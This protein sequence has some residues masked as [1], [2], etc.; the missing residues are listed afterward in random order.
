MSHLF[1]PLTI[2][3]V[4]LRNRIGVSPMCQYSATD[5]VPNDWHLVHYGSRATG[6]AGLIIVEAAAVE[7]RGRISPEDLG[8]YSEEQIPA[9]QR[10]TAFMKENGAVPGIQLAHAGRKASTHSPFKQQGSEPAVA[11]ENGGWD[12]IGP[13]ALPF[14]EGYKTPKEATI[15]EIKEIQ[16]KFRQATIAAAKAG[17]EWLEFHAAHGYLAHSFYSPLSNKRT[18]EYGGSFENRIRFTLETAQIMR[19][20]WPDHLPFTVRISATDWTEGGWTIEE[21]VELSKRLKALGVD[22]IDCS[23]GGNVSDAK[24]PVGAGYQ[25]TF[26]ERIRNEASIATAAVGLITQGMQADELIRNE[27]A[28]L[29]LI[30]REFLRD[31]YWPLRAATTVHK[32]NDLAIPPQYARGW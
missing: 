10:L 9:Y 19:E 17:F 23:T 3:D 8:M 14:A 7:P 30:G 12:V 13:S 18:D 25:N 6:G 32:I 22:L 20:A 28:D 15:E 31:P 27:K 16:E 21:S 24:I 29:I 1:S 5:G 4:T 2:K 26:A 11:T